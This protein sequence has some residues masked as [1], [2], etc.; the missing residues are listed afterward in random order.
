MLI[1][2]HMT[3]TKRNNTVLSLHLGSILSQTVIRF[4]LKPQDTFPAETGGTYERYWSDHKPFFFFFF[5]SFLLHQGCCSFTKVKVIWDE[6]KNNP[7]N[8]FLSISDLFFLFFPLLVLPLKLGFAHVSACMATPYILTGFFAL[9]SSISV[10]SKTFALSPLL[11]L[12]IWKWS[13]NMYA[14]EARILP[15]VNRNA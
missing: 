11:L 3:N 12:W 13:M 10:D 1:S 6:K 4:L 7:T 9:K 15:M 8:T 2:C 14:E 5:F